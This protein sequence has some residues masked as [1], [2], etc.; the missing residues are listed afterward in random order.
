MARHQKSK[1]SSWDWNVFAM[2]MDA[3][4]LFYWTDVHWKMPKPKLLKVDERNEALKLYCD[5]EGLASTEREHVL[6]FH[7]RTIKVDICYLIRIAP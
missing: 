1:I 5:S 7:I 6:K 2:L 3:D 4:Q